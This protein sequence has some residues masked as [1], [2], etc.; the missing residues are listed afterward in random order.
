MDEISDL[1]ARLG[2]LDLDVELARAD[3]VRWRGVTSFA[4]FFRPLPLVAQVYPSCDGRWTDEDEHMTFPARLALDGRGR[5]V[6]LVRD[7][8]FSDGERP[9]VVWHYGEGWLEQL[10][11]RGEVLRATLD[12]DRV[13]R[14]VAVREEMTRFE[15]VAWDEDVAVRADVVRRRCDGSQERLVRTALIGIDG[16]VERVFVDGD[17]VWDCRVSR[18]EPWPEDPVGLVEPL[19]RALDRALRAA[20]L[21]SGVA[22]PFCVEVHSGGDGPAWPPFARLGSSAFRDRMRRSSRADAAAIDHLYLG[23]EGGDVARL[24]VVDELDAEALRACRALSTALA[25]GSPYNPD[26][27]S[28]ADAVAERLAQLL[29]ANPP[30][31]SVDPFLALVYTGS[32][33]LP[34]ALERARRVA[35]GERVEAFLASVAAPSARRVPASVRALTDRRALE[36]LLAERGLKA[37]AR[38]LSREVAHHGL[39]LVPGDGPS[40]LGGPPLLPPDTRWPLTTTGVPLTF[41]AAIRLED[42]A[43]APGGWLLFYAALDPDEDGLVD[44]ELNTPGASARV[45]HTTDPVAADGPALQSRPLAVRRMLTL[46]DGFEASEQLGLDVYEGQTYSEILDELADLRRG[47]TGTESEHWFGGLTTGVQ[48]FTPEPGTTLLL[49][50]AWDEELGFEFLDCGVIQFRVPTSALT[51]GDWSRIVAYPDSC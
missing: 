38:R 51:A 41:L 48:G 4:T 45:L 27:G 25:P 29:C 9:V 46:P 32:S 6:A 23:E 12:G 26:A 50:I 3:V 42:A 40:H 21:A 10:D 44:D 37:H 1:R 31:G 18:P 20:A 43:L 33:E 7:G 34:A 47:D 49:H 15:E 35:G 22:E 19:A 14:I 24:S 2:E 17:L 5:P 8:L 13:V 36:Q 39:L 11:A 28:V 16:D 30:A